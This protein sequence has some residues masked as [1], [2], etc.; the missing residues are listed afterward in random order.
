ML[1]YPGDGRDASQEAN[2]GE[3]MGDKKMLDRMEG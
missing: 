3:K 1:Q 2:A